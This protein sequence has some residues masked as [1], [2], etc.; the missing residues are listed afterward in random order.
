MRDTNLHI[1]GGC[2]RFETPIILVD[3]KPMITIPPKATR[4]WSSWAVQ[5]GAFWIWMVESLAAPR[6]FHSHPSFGI[7]TWVLVGMLPI[8]LRLSGT[9]SPSGWVRIGDRGRF[10]EKKV[11]CTLKPGL[12]KSLPH[13]GEKT[14]NSSTSQ[15]CRQGLWHFWPRCLSEQRRWASKLARKSDVLRPIVIKNGSGSQTKW[16]MGCIHG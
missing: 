16:F 4:P 7:P 15:P 14:S 5:T 6:I 9:I 3:L 13:R 11:E 12:L 10:R 2:L 1:P 8:C